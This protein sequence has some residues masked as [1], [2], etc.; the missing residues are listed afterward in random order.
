VRVLVVEDETK[1]ALAIARGLQGEGFEV[2]VAE[3]GERGLRAAI[4]RSYDVILLD[5]M[6]PGLDGREVC[7]RLRQVENWTPILVLTAL[8]GPRSEAD[9]LG[10]GAD[11]Y[12]TKP[13]TFPVL[14]ARMRALLR[15]AGRSADP[16]CRVGDLML[17]SRARRCLR[18]DVEIE[19]TSREFELLD[20]MA[21]RAGETLSKEAILDNVWDMNFEGDPNLVEV[22]IRRLRNKID[23]PFERDTIAT[24]RGAG[25]RI[26]SDE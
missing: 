19:L 7:S 14:L 17:D 4:E 18:G 25:Y 10:V 16:E 23:R 13:F 26:Q 15:R 9:L 3:D 20:F 8:D 11:D 24:V 5:L 21:R 1:L 22:Y 6:L 12:V 2:D